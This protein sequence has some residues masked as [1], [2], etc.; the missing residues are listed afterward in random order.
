MFKSLDNIS[1]PDMNRNNRQ[2]YLATRSYKVLTRKA[3]VIKK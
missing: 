3:R 2:R 1:E